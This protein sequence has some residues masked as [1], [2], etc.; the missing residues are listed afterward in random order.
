MI[1][2]VLNGERRVE[3]K[4]NICCLKRYMSSK[5]VWIPVFAKISWKSL[6][7]NVNSD[8]AKIEAERII[9][10]HLE[11]ERDLKNS[12]RYILLIFSE[13]WL[14]LGFL[15]KISK[16]FSRRSNRRRNKPHST[17]NEKF[18]RWKYI[19]DWWNCYFCQRSTALYICSSGSRWSPGHLPEETSNRVALY[20]RRWWNTISTS[21][22]RLCIFDLIKSWSNQRS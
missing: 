2:W 4:E 6:V 5:N 20:W 17:T 18:Q 21:N 10:T 14:A 1:L 16:I 7:R 19:E 12:V 22:N 13:I 11:Y 8:T 3:K 15:R 9:E